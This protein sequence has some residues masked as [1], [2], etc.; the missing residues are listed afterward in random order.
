MGKYSPSPLPPLK[1]ASTAR[2][3]P[4][5]KP[6]TSKPLVSALAISG[7]GRSGVGGSSGG[8]GG[9]SGL[10]SLVC[11][12]S[13]G[14]SITKLCRRSVVWSFSTDP[15]LLIRLCITQNTAK[16]A[17]PAA[18]NATPKRGRLDCISTRLRCQR[19]VVHTGGPGGIHYRDQHL[20]AGFFVGLNHHRALRVFRVHPFNI[21]AHLA[22]FD[23]ALINPDFAFVVHRNQ[24]IGAWFGH[25]RTGIRAIYVNTGFFYK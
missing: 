18:S 24:N 23:L 14:V 11:T 25:G 3:A 19:H 5:S 1:P 7:L 10:R 9:F 20:G 13:S 22:F 6:L 8:A 4:I 15:P 21:G 12:S 2:S 16:V 17:S